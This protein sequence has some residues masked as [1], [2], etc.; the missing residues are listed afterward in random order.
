MNK[1]FPYASQYQN[2]CM[3]LAT[4]HTPTRTSTHIAMAINRIFIYGL[5]FNLNVISPLRNCKISTEHLPE[6]NSQSA[7]Q[8]VNP[9]VSL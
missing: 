8:S 4:T 5:Q 2:R 7:N 6:V 3:P 1:A 9:S